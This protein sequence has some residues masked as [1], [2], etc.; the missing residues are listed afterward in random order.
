M[1]SGG[2]MTPE[3]AR[4]QQQIFRV[5]NV[6]MRGLLSLPFATPISRRLMLVHYSGRK[7]GKAY[8]QPVSY[9]EDGD[10]L[11]TPG[12]GN[13]KLNLSEDQSVRIHLKGRD[14][15]AHPEL[16]REPPEVEQLLKKMMA[17][18]PRMTSFIPFIGSDKQ[19]DQE[20]LKAAVEHGFCI[21]RWHLQDG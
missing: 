11:L 19:I 8:R 14:V 7:T 4:R 2:G 10:T 15:Q 18:N 17:V 1:A 5:V 16:V 9:V 3:K 20:K 21:V 12:G 13:W 6:P